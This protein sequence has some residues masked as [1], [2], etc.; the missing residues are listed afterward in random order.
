MSRI[1]ASTWRKRWHVAFDE[2][3]VAQRAER[4][5]NAKMERIRSKWLDAAGRERA[6]E[7]I[8][9]IGP[10]DEPTGL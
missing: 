9:A 8:A 10:T 6:A 4:K 5:A 1:K 2:W 3:V 7:G